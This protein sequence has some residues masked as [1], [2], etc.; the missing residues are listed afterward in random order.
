[1]DESALTLFYLNLAP[2]L[3]VTAQVFLEGPFNTATNLMN[4]ALRSS[5][6]PTRFPGKPIPGNAVDSIQIEIRGTIGGLLLA[7]AAGEK[8]A[9]A[10]RDE[11]SQSDANSNLVEK[12][13]VASVK[14]GDSEPTAPVAANPKTSQPAWLMNDGTIRNFADTTKDYVQFDTT[15]G[16]Y[17]IVVRHRNHLAIISRTSQALSNSA[18]LFYDFRADSTTAFGTGAMKPVGTNKYAMWAGDVT[19]NGV[20]QYNLPGND[21][22]PILVRIG[23]TNINNTV[24]GY[25]NEDVNLDGIVRYNLPGNDRAIIIVNIGG[26]NINAT[27]TT[28]VP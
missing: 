17:Y 9:D 11:N 15:A 27:R 6:L 24:S 7:N 3:Q 14:V 1:M 10:D 16:N 8:V 5:I 23:G 21:R 20:I 26:A 18:Q 2:Q 4:N 12:S 25:F 13:D 28:Q 19:G 22:A